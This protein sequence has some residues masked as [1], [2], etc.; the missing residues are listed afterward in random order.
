MIVPTPAPP[1]P[2]GP[3]RIPS[4]RA[5]NIAAINAS[6]PTAIIPGI[7]GSY[8]VEVACA[9]LCA[10]GSF[11]IFR[12]C[13]RLKRHRLRGG[14]HGGGESG[15]RKAADQAQQECTFFHG[16][17]LRSA[18]S[19]AV[20]GCTPTRFDFAQFSMPVGMVRA[21]NRFVMVTRS[22]RARRNKPT[23]WDFL[24]PANS[25]RRSAPRL[26]WLLGRLEISQRHRGGRPHRPNPLSS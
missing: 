15:C 26:S 4:G 17:S 8:V 3:P 19:M 16:L 1:I 25:G 22:V 7:L 13:L 21:G 23:P 9:D 14:H 24:G 6:G 20:Y 18:S 5:P 11:D 2:S 12:G 10:F